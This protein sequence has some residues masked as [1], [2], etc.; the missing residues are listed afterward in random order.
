MSEA[1]VKGSPRAC[2]GDMYPTVP[3]TTFD[4]RNRGGHD[5]PRRLRIRLELRE[6]EVED[7]HRMAICQEE[8]LRLQ[9]PMNNTGGMGSRQSIGNRRS[10]LGDLAPRRLRAFKQG[11]KRFAFEEFSYEEQRRLLQFSVEDGEDVGVRKCGNG[12]RFNAKPR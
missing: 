2:S 10:Q 7:L 5:C 6:A 1:G 11:P 4:I 12:F 9:I 8:V 3:N